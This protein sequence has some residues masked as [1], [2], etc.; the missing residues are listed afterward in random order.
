MPIPHGFVERLAELSQNG[1]PFVCVT[2]V[3]AVGSTPQDAG[4]KMLVTKDGLAFGTIGGG[5]VEAKAIDVAKEMLGMQ[6]RGARNE[7][8]ADV[9]LLAP[10][11]SL[12]T[13][14]LKRDVGMTCGGTVKLFFETYNHN[15]WRIIVFGAGHVAAAVI[16]CLRQLDCHVT[17]VDPRAEWLDRIPDGSRL[18]KVQADDPRSLV[19]GLPRDAFV[20]CMTMGHATDRPILE[21]IFRQGHTFPFLGVIGS[22]AKRAVLVK[23]LT[24]AGIEA[25]AAERFYCPIGLDLGTNQP[26]EI[27]VS[28]VAQLIQER[29]GWRREGRGARSEIELG[30]DA[31]SSLLAPRSLLRTRRFDVVEQTVTKPDG[32]TASIQYVRHGGSVAILPLVDDEHICLIKS[33]RLTVNET[34]IEVPAGTREPDEPPLETARRELAEETGFRAG[35]IDELIRYYP[36][37]GVLSEMMHVFVARDLVPGEPAR[38]ENEEIENLVVTLEE[39][40]EMVKRGEIK[41][42][43]TIVALLSFDNARK[44]GTA[45]Q[46]SR[47]CKAN[48]SNV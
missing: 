38:E 33:R 41:D 42:G 5:R 24:A 10:R 45:S 7:E 31:H 34:L 2:M 6:E 48:K 22:R 18:R 17:C 47:S 14:N 8:R 4:S 16:E 25:D 11:S 26:G 20:I 46:G 9:S 19:S 1:V 12:L 44:D 37:P 40:L 21:E 32:R 39:A 43:K 13:W 3:E 28:V 36:S 35:R 27:A 23:E 15:E 30:R 29:D